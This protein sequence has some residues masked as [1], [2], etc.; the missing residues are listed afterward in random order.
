MPNKY[1]PFVAGISDPLDALAPGPQNQEFGPRRKPTPP[2]TEPPPLSPR[3]ATFPGA[4][5]AVI[6]QESAGDP[7]AVSSVGAQ[8]LMQLMPG[9]AADLGVTDSFDPVQNRDGGTR[10]LQ[11]QLTEFNSWELAL[12]AYNWGPGNV[13]RW[14]D[15]GANPEEVPDETR[16]YLEAILPQVEQMIEDGATATPAG[17][18]KASEVSA[19]E[20]AEV[21][22][23]SAELGIPASVVARNVS[24]VKRV[25]SANKYTKYAAVVTETLGEDPDFMAIAHDDTDNMNAF[26]R[27]AGSM[28]FS[29][30]FSAGIDKVE[31]LVSRFT[32]ATGELF[33]SEELAAFGRE[34]AERNER[35]T[36][37]A[38]PRSKFVDISTAGDFVQWLKEGAGDQIPIFAGPLAGGAAGAAIGLLGGPAAPVTVPLGAAIGTFIPSFILG[39]GETQG[40]I[41]GRD[42]DTVAPGVAFSAGA[43]IGA[44]DSAIP[45][46]LGTRLVKGFGVDI[47]EQVVKRLVVE[48]PKA[49]LKNS[50][51]EGVTEGVQTVISEAAAAAATGTELDVD[52]LSAEIVESMALGFFM[53]G[54]TTLG[55]ETTVG[56]VKKYKRASAA[57]RSMD[58]LNKLAGE[59]KVKERDPAKRNAFEAKALAE[60]GIE[61]VGVKARA[62]LDWAQN[63]KDGPDAAL[64]SLG[65][66][67]EAVSVAID[68]DGDVPVTAEQLSENFLGDEEA[69]NT[70][71]NDL[72]PSSEQGTV[73][74]AVA[75]LS[76]AAVELKAALDEIEDI[77]PNLGERMAGLITELSGETEKV[78]EALDKAPADVRAVLDQLV[79]TVVEERVTTEK[80]QLDARRDALETQIAAID[81]KTEPLV[82][83]IEAAEAE[84]RGTVQRERRLAKLEEQRQVLDDDLFGL[85]EPSGATTLGATSDVLTPPVPGEVVAA[86]V[87]LNEQLEA[88]RGRKATADEDVKRAERQVSG[89][90]TAPAAV[91]EDDSAEALGTGE[92]TRD[93]F[94][95]VTKGTK[96]RGTTGKEYE[97]VLPLGEA[98]E[99]AAERDKFT[100]NF[101][102]HIE[103]SIPG[104]GE[105]Q[106]MVGH[107]I[108]ET[109]PEGGRM[110]DIGGSEGGLAKGVAEHGIAAEVLDPNPDMEATFN[111]K[112]QVPGATYRLE[113]FGTNP[114][115]DGKVAFEDVRF[116]KLEEGAYNIVHESMV[117]Q[118]IDNGR[119]AQV[120]RV[121][122]L[123]TP[124]GMAIFQ[125]KYLATEENIAAWDAAEAQKDEFKE[126]YFSKAEISR[127]REEVLIGMHRFMVTPESFE[128]TLRANFEF[129][130]QYWDS[131]NF[132]GYVATNNPD[133]M[134]RF[135]SGLPSTNSEF[136]TVAT[137]RT[138]A[139][140]TTFEDLQPEN[141]QNLL[142]RGDVAFIEAATGAEN[143]AAR[144]EELKELLVEQ[145]IPFEDTQGKFKGVENEGVVIFAPTEVARAI[146]QQFGQEAVLTGEGLIFADG[147]TQP[148]TAI[149]PVEDLFP[150]DDFTRIPSTG[151]TF[152]VELDEDAS[153]NA[154]ESR[155]LLAERQQKAL[156]AQKDVVLAEEAVARSAEAFAPRPAARER[157]LELKA[158]TLDALEVKTTRQ[159]VRALR[160]GFRVGIKVTQ[161]NLKILQDQAKAAV[162]ASP[163]VGKQ[164]EAVLAQISSV[165][166]VRRLEQLKISIINRVETQRKREI[167]SAVKRTLSTLSKRKGKLTPEVQTIVDNLAKVAKLSQAEAAIELEKRAGGM[168]GVPGVEGKLEN[169]ILAAI[170]NPKVTNANNLENLLLELNDLIGDAKKIRT[171][172]ELIRAFEASTL[173]DATMDALGPERATPRGDVEQKLINAEA[174]GLA[175]NG[176]WATKLRRV[177]TSS[178]TAAVEETLSKLSLFDE[179]RVFEQNKI[180]STARLVELLQERFPGLSE[181][182][183]FRKMYDSMTEEVN[184]GTFTHADGKS[185]SI[186]MKRSELRQRVMEMRNEQL[187]LLARHERGNAYTDEIIEALEGALTEDDIHMVDA[188]QQFYNDFYARIN[189]VYERIYG[190]S[191]PQIENYVPIKREFT[192]QTTDE[193]LANIHFTGSLNPSAIKTRQASVRPLLKA[194]DVVRLQSHMMQ[195]EYFIAFAE[196]VRLLNDVFGGDNAVVSGRIRANF[197]N[198]MLSGIKKDLEYFANRG[199][200]SSLTGE[201]MFVKLLRNYSF[202]QLGLSPQIGFKQLVSSVAYAENVKSV[203]FFAGVAKF[204]AN[205]KKAL[206]FMNDNSQL[207]RNRGMNLDQDFADMVRD[208]NSFLGKRPKLTRFIMAPIRWGDRSAIAIGGYAHVQAQLKAGKTQEQAIR[209]FERITVDTQQSQDPDQVSELQ[210][211]NALLRV[212]AQFMSSANALA[213]A[214]YVAI[215]E[216]VRGRITKQELA[217]RILILHFVIPTMIQFIA[218]AFHWDSDDQ[219]RAVILGAFNGVFILG[220]VVEFAVGSALGAEN[221]FDLGI[222]H[223]LELVEDIVKAV[224]AYGEDDYGVDE[225]FEGIYSLDRGLRA[226]GALSGLP[227]AKLYGEVRGLG[228]VVSGENVVG[229]GALMLGWSPYIVDK[230]DIGN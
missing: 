6:Q 87:A 65:T 170:G 29:T 154:P 228:Q 215:T 125:E 56:A 23:L 91:F 126:Q 131:G 130:A 173:R 21:Q 79:Q 105:I 129:V 18:M 133:T 88:A 162:K 146:A 136:S 55:V 222:R 109:F 37:A 69:Y 20:A 191:L 60:A 62:V 210:R 32:E 12:M 219:K 101:D 95:D 205:P 57:R 52:E 227:L 118:F 97:P 190:F 220:D 13:Q 30:A 225:F 182:Q 223:P 44:L 192:D 40:A 140:P 197:G 181:T 112:P 226:G 114:A 99:F 217:K 199:I 218:N 96:G 49:V 33:G 157:G 141:I 175:W 155:R 158:K 22:K 9:T 24:E 216:A 117:F 61:G 142:G 93:F 94:S 207:F 63:H 34:A 83:E 8:G 185:Q 172:G 132:K 10:Y 123:L 229:G 127:K 178:D 196:K 122:G 221:V 206:R 160:K 43:V 230:F 92:E 2:T 54:G 102:V 53:G 144:L 183:L 4:I 39:V 98:E 135:L 137:P 198:D 78:A 59:S 213:R 149:N 186:I 35:E 212:S 166:T 72:R 139:A 174:V 138:V 5:D 120:E 51:I 153:F 106:P 68:E 36:A 164:R 50:T 211:S 156:K 15:N 108:V 159:A 84:G 104:Y 26:A 31:G 187:N 86:D 7:N 71:R 116:A 113:A 184:V 67:I 17:H 80:I 110:L 103:T 48:V 14:I 147:T 188:Q 165:K 1:A 121:A 41:K 150:E 119:D 124:E 151:A 38:G 209:S 161:E 193:F 25:A 224:G 189:A 152:T 204:V 128:A 100:G 148:A 134:S 81:L 111:E 177:F 75:P 163:L 208:A 176:A 11:Q 74:E 143:D 82:A 42:P 73:S 171:A 77:A 45:G 89:V 202:A 70:I 85:P 115:E 168:E 195:M 169:M 47:A 179:A 58:E 46:K 64:E 66:N 145:G 27:Q 28:T 201:S 180:D 16:G 90:D 107:A 3:L 203:D 194:H 200:L 167:L 19:D 76:E 214:E